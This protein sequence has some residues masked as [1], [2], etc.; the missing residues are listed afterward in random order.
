[1]PAR[2]APAPPAYAAMR[3]RTACAP[4]VRKGAPLS[5]ADLVFIP[6]SGML[7]LAVVASDKSGA[8]AGAMACRAYEARAKTPC[9]VPRLGKVATNHGL[10]RGPSTANGTIT[11]PSCAAGARP[12]SRG[13]SRARGRGGL[14]EVLAGVRRP[15]EVDE[16]ARDGRVRLESIL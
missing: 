2:A 13:S 16:G 10:E 12:A 8:N 3:A 15:V 14:A 11:S 1:M 7:P 9:A 5:R 4:R 6:V